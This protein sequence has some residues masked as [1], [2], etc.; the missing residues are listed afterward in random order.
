MKLLWVCPVNLKLQQEFIIM[1]S[2]SWNEELRVFCIF[3][4]LQPRVDKKKMLLKW[5]FFLIAEIHL[6]KLHLKVEEQSDIYGTFQR[7]HLRKKTQIIKWSQTVVQLE[8]F[9][10]RCDLSNT[11]FN[12][13]KSSSPLKCI[14]IITVCVLC[15][16][17]INWLFL[18]VF[19]SLWINIY[20]QMP[21]MALSGKNESF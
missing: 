19:G 15:W 9:D 1:M 18:S 8:D 11:S 5:L 2:T 10:E 20:S 3:N 13:K 16:L 14:L 6:A 4:L 17:L 21:A 7:Y 12:G